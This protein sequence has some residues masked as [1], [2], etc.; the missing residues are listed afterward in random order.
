[1][2]NGPMLLLKV[3]GELPGAVLTIRGEAAVSFEALARGDLDRVEIVMD[4]AVVQTFRPSADPH[5][6]VASMKLR[7]VE[8]GWLAA[9][10]FERSPVTVRFA[11]TSP[12][13]FGRQA[14][15]VPAA[16]AYLREWVDADAARINEVDSL[17][18]AQKEEL[19]SECARARSR[20][21]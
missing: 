5:R 12:V 15:R 11:H 3:N 19:L 10:C 14:R 2:T 20:Y 21:E 17:T 8:G 7:P 6:I 4:G 16:L 9:R 13:Y 18:A 1:M